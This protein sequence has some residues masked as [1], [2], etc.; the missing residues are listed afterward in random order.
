MCSD[1]IV[2]NRSL[3]KEEIFHNHLTCFLTINKF[4]MTAKLCIVNE[5][6]RLRVTNIALNILVT[7]GNSFMK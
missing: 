7:A 5:G 1:V 3:L 6:N 4:L 2:R